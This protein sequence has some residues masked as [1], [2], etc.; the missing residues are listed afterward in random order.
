MGASLPP[1]IVGIVAGVSALVG[2]IGISGVV[3]AVLVTV[4]SGAIVAAGAGLTIWGVGTLIAS[5]GSAIGAG[6]GGVLLPPISADTNALAPWNVVYGRSRVGGAIVYRGSFGDNDKYLDL[7]IILA[8]HRSEAVDWL[9]FDSKKIQIGDRADTANGWYG[10]SFTPLQQTIAVSSP[11]DITRDS[12]V[13]TLK[14]HTDIPLLD[15]GDDIIVSAVHPVDLLFN[16][17]FPVNSVTRAGGILTI[18]YLCGGPAVPG[19]GTITESGQVKTD[20]QDYGRKIYME[21]MLGGQALGDTFVGMTDGTPYDGDPDDP[22]TNDSNPW[23]SDC[24]LVNKTAV[25]LRLHYNEKYFGQGIPQIS[26]LLK[27]KKDIYD[28][29]TET[30]S[31]TENAALIIAD[32]LN[33]PTWGYK[34]AYTTEIPLPELITAANICD[35]AVEL[36]QPSSSPARTEPRYA[37]N[38]GF[39]LTTRRVE[40]L[41]NLLTSCAGRLTYIGGQ[42]RLYPGAWLGVST[43]YSGSSIYSLLTGGFRWKATAS[44]IQ[45]FN[46]VKGTY[47]SPV[48]KWQPA[49]MPRYAQDE[50]HGYT[51]GTAPHYDANLDADGGDRRWLD[52]QLPFTISPSTAQ[53]IAKIELL[54]RRSQGTGTFPLNMA[55]YN[56]VPMDVVSLDLPFFGWTGKLLEVAA[57]RLKMTDA[58]DGPPA[59]SVEIDVQETDPSIYSWSVGEELSPEGYQQAIVPDTR[60]PAAPTNFLASSTN[61]SIFLT[62][63]APEDAFVVHGGHVEIEYR[64][65]ASPPGLWI[66]LA[67]M[68]PAVTQAE[69][70]NLV[71]GTAY[72]AQI[73]SVNA[74]GVPSDWVEVTPAESSPL[75]AGPITV[76]PPLL[77]VPNYETPVSGFLFGEKGFGVAPNY[78]LETD[79]VVARVNVY[80]DQPEPPVALVLKSRRVL[81]TGPFAQTA[82]VVT[83]TSPVV[84][85]YGVIGFGGTGLPVD[86]FK[87]RVLSKLANP[88]GSTNL[89][90]MFDCVITANDA[91]GNFTVTPDPVA[92]GCGAGDL[93]TLRSGRGNGSVPVSTPITADAI[94]YT[95]SLFANFYNAGLTIHENKGNLALVIAGTGAGQTPQTVVDNTGTKVTVAPGW[96][97]IPDETSVVILVEALPQAFLPADPQTVAGNRLVGAF[98]ID[99]YRRRVVRIEGYTSKGVSGPIETVPA[100]EIYIWGL[101][102]SDPAD[103]IVNVSADVTLG[104]FPQMVLV[105]SSAGDVNITLPQLA[106]YP[107]MVGKKVIIVKVSTDGNTVYVHGNGSETIGFSGSESLINQGDSIT[108]EAAHA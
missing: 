70:S 63:D 91:S 58:S 83:H 92:A 1:V 9:L 72:D 27:G 89:I 31:Y 74:A 53:R 65:V 13:V 50:A 21:V 4:I 59:L 64:P 102:G 19:G 28:P 24:S 95:D 61:A 77:W 79:G 38:G 37:C 100:R 86:G 3:G 5:A 45:L 41:Q 43:T 82:A 81:V 7:V 32:Y 52:V 57:S 90:P 46:G 87:G 68:D 44:V 75:A 35:E 96:D 84:S 94:S 15:V 73:R 54:R 49:D 40:V 14:L 71:V 106:V 56:L 23:T 99:N 8:C 93:F 17:K 51:W 85:G 107:Q 48:N 67:K 18:T 29:R 2:A 20:W 97:L 42:F 16:G 62:W 108:I 104:A 76:N 22:Q 33:Q 10:T 12:N 25:F 101:Q 39:L 78:T 47:I 55:A 30:H 66:S 26:F 6:G 88:E 34:A 98:P 80:G 36:A 11:S 105:D 60:T 69:I 103:N